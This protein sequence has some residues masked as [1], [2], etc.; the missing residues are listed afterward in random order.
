AGLS[1]P[2][3]VLPEPQI[4]SLS[5]PYGIV[6]TGVGGTGVVTIGALLGMAA[7]I[8]GKGVS[9]LDMTGLAQKG[10]AVVSHVRLAETPEDIHAVRISAGSARLLLGCDLVVAA[11]FDALSK[12]T[13][14]ETHAVINSRETVTGDFTRDPDF[15]VPGAELRRLIENAAGPDRSDFLDASS[16]AT[17]LLG[18]SIATNLFMLGYAWQKGLVPLS[19]DAIF[20]AIDLNAVAVDA[21]KRAF[22]W[23]RRAAEDLAA[24]T[25]AAL[26]KKP[27]RSLRLSESLEEGIERRVRFL[28][29]YQN[30]AYADRYAAAV[31]RV[32]AAE[33]ALMPGER[34]LTAAVMRYYFKLLA[35]KDEY[36]VA[37]LHSLPDFRVKLAQQFQGDYKL[38][39]HLAPPL[40]AARDPQT[41]H[42]KKREYGGWIFPL[43]GALAKLKGLRG[44]PFDPFGYSAERRVERQL[45][46][47]YEAL[48][49]ELLAKLTRE[50]HGLAVALAS[51]P[52][53]IRGY[54][55]VKDASIQKAEAEAAELLAAFRDPDV[56]KSAAE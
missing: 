2:W 40:F 21:N 23:G 4:P 16:L 24:V 52:E 8:D 19:E 11:G 27:A 36:E 14:G 37:R 12:V 10:G 15:K 1:E 30:K 42:L 43:F 50:N 45:I 55:H 9:V 38:S 51:I 5:S 49:D 39:V 34:G 35:V 54:G 41:G 26:P 28:T 56:R 7:H 32:R 31:A 18:D 20:A 44:T 13:S 3:P 33:E 29:D 6:I 17:A 22:T 46:A 53:K 25:K 48:L 47:G